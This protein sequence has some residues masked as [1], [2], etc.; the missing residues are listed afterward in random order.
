MANKKEKW[1]MENEIPGLVMESPTYDALTERVRHAVP[2][3][4]ALNH[5]QQ[6]DVRIVKC[7]EEKEVEDE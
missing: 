6:G 2:E 5:L 4:L 7:I 1:G 3:L